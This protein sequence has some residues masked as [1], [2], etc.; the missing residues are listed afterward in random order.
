MFKF[1]HHLLESVDLGGSFD[2]QVVKSLVLVQQ[3][4]DLDA[5][6]TDSGVA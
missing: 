2:D 5:Q 1:D 6:L 4:G 3:A